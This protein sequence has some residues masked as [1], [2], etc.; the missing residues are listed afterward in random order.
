MAYRKN[1]EQLVP[2]KGTDRLQVVNPYDG[3]VVTSDIH[4]AT[5]EDVDLAVAAAE[6]AFKTG[7]WATFTGSQRAACLF[8]LADLYERDAEKMGKLETASIGVSST[9][10]THGLVPHGAGILRFYAG[11]ADKIQGSTLATENGTYGLIRKQPYGV[12]AGIGAWNATLLYLLCK[13]GTAVAAGNTVCALREKEPLR[14]M[15]VS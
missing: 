7:P 8:K 12:V 10:V 4:V 1:R 14:L 6:V 11:L 3:S 13:V 5:A 9:I 15:V 2:S